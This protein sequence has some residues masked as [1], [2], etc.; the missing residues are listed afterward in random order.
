MD[1]TAQWRR[2]APGSLR[3]RCDTWPVVPWH[4]WP[5]LPSHPGS[6]PHAPVLLVARVPSL[7]EELLTQA[8]SRPQAAG[9]RRAPTRRKRGGAA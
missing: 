3:A 5:P 1:P 8:A 4:V 9:G 2:R 6:N 7:R